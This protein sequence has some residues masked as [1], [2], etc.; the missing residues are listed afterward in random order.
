M[1]K[2]KRGEQQ[3]PA[4]PCTSETRLPPSFAFQTLIQYAQSFF[5][6][7]PESLYHPPFSL[8]YIETYESLCQCEL[9]LNSYVEP[10]AIRDVIDECCSLYHRIFDQP[11]R[12]FDLK[13]RIED[14]EFNAKLK[15]LRSCSS[16]IRNAAQLSDNIRDFRYI[17]YCSTSFC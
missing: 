2:R 8:E 4:V 13:E 14:L 5:P 11:N 3:E 17:S 7:I 6:H 1:N 15:W 12:T 10:H 16:I 9:Q